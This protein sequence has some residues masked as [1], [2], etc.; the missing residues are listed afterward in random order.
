MSL[1]WIKLDVDLADHPKAHDLCDRLDE[2]LAWARMVL[3]W[4]YCAKFAPDGIIRGANPGRTIERAARWAGKAGRFV[5]CAIASGFLRSVEGGIEAHDFVDR[6]GAHADRRR[7][8]A[9]RKRRARGGSVSARTSAG[10]DADSPP[11]VG[12]ESAGRSAGHSTGHPQDVGALEERREDLP[13]NPPPGGG[14]DSGRTRRRRRDT[15]EPEAPPRIEDPDK[16]L[17]P[18]TPESRARLAEMLGKLPFMRG[19]A[20]EPAEVAS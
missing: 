17:P 7:K 13:P 9:E 15:P 20:D 16:D 8:D 18:A 4:S 1:P 14:S 19:S 2:P 11:D 5:E 6:N 10:H 3:V 12:S